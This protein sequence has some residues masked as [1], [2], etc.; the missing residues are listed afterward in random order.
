LT[1]LL[2]LCFLL[3]AG[4]STADVSAAA[5][6]LDPTLP[7]PL[8]VSTIEYD[9]G[10][11]LIASQ[12]PTHP[13]ASPQ[14]LH[15]AIYLPAGP[16]PFPVVTLVHGRH[17]TCYL[18]LIE[19]VP[20]WVG[21]F[22]GEFPLHPCPSTS[23]S[24]DIPSY[25]GYDYIGQN[26][27]SH[28]YLVSS[29][30]VNGINSYDTATALVE[31]GQFQRA[32]LIA[33]SIDLLHDWNLASG[34][35][36]VGANLIGK[37]DLSRL[38]LMGHS[39]GGEGVTAFVDHNRTRIGRQYPGLK[40][41]FALAPTD[42]HSWK[43]RG[44]NFATLLPLCDGDVSDLQGASAYDNGRF[45]DPNEGFAR[46]QY[47]VRG[48][49]HNYFNTVWSKAT[50]PDDWDD[51][52]HAF[53]SDCTKAA[54]GNPTS[55][56]LSEAE[57]Q[58][59]GLALIAAFQR[60]YV[61]N[62]LGFEEFVKGAAPLATSSCP[63]NGV[64]CNTVIRTSYLG[65]ANQRQL[66]VTPVS[67]SPTVPPATNQLGGSLTGTGFDV[68]AACTPGTRSDALASGTFSKESIF[69]PFTNEPCPTDPQ[70]GRARQ[71]TLS[72]SGS[73]TLTADLP[74]AGFDARQF[75]A[76]TFRTGVNFDKNDETVEVPQD[77]EVVL[78]DTLGVTATVNAASFTNS[79]LPPDGTSN[80]RLTLNGAR[81]PLRSFTS[82]DRRKLTKIELRFGS[83]TSSG[84]LQLAELG[85]QK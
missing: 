62:E 30:D 31:D 82:I 44:V 70:A 85:F 29:I 5:Q 61:G 17:A 67:G 64:A 51:Y 21:P 74:P 80:R 66:I 78:T 54:N 18:P 14:Q 2:L 42:F 76:L 24:S 33:R 84:S 52:G 56:R 81:I 48:T 55:A 19:G 32:E 50:F 26:L 47:A 11:T 77:F 10:L 49:N 39:R 41:V 83:L 13:G 58:K 16:G 73:A 79:L 15:G 63:S 9:A 69:G 20:G 37:V 22:P 3:G 25:R 34:P 6:A 60:R 45:V 7:G 57:Q 23:L 46:A 35:G 1:A 68:Y 72:W 65:P 71:L 28:G 38:G 43:P 12:S 4:L 40:A 75:N 59:V 8:P 36:S 53:D 27:A